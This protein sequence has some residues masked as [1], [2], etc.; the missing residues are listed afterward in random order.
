MN[1]ADLEPKA[2]ISDLVGKGWTQQRIG[3]RIGIE[4]ATVS[5]VLRGDTKDVMSAT[6]RKLLALHAEVMRPGDAGKPD[7]PTTAQG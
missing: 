6:Y 7:E 2:L 1:V 3:E 5:K 4:Q